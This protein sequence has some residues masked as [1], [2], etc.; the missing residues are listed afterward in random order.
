M[1]MKHFFISLIFIPIIC[2]AE[3]LEPVWTRFQRTQAELLAVKELTPEAAKKLLSLKADEGRLSDSEFHDAE[4]SRMLEEV[5]RHLKDVTSMKYSNTW[6]AILEFLSWQRE[7]NI[8]AVSGNRTIVTTNGGPCLGGGAQKYNE[9]YNFFFEGCFYYGW[10]NVGSDS[11]DV[12]Y[13]KNDIPTLGMRLAPGAG[14]FIS[15]SKT[16]I[17]IKLPILKI[18]QDIPEPSG[19]SLSDDQTVTAVAAIYFRYPIDRLR[20]ELDFGKFVDEDTTLWSVGLGY[21]F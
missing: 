8:T 7:R 3:S 4:A 16:E 5:E 18:W 11:T 9:R 13:K 15:Q 17:G 10:A 19:H 14:L 21:M 12:I 1:A 6:Y 2:W 20:F